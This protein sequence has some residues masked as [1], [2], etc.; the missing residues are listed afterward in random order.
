MSSNEKKSAAELIAR[1][2]ADPTHRAELRRRQAAQ[3]ARISVNRDA[4][5]PIMRELAVAG[6]A[7]DSFAE[8]RRASSYISAIAILL[9]WLP[10][11][12]NIDIK[13]DIVRCLSVPD[14]K[15]IAAPALIGEFKRA[16]GVT[17]SGLRWTI[18]NAL[19]V[20]ADDAVADELLEIALNPGYG[21]A[22]EM[23][24]VALGNLSGHLVVSGLL[25]LLKDENVNGHAVKALATLALPATR[26]FVEPFTQHSK[27]WVRKEAAR[28]L[29]RIDSRRV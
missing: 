22:R 9:K 17:P 28:A 21:A 11:T 8:L 24:V 13:E 16:S 1:L 18:G 25:D 29:A 14:A 4:A 7:V 5:A 23:V 19:E 6:F 27:A 10:I 3:E 2:Q 12:S 15:P 26:R 20:V